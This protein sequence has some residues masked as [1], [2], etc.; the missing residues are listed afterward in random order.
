MLIKICGLCRR[1]DAAVAAGA[2]ATHV[3]VIRVS[4]AAR[5]RPTAVARSVLAGAR[6]CRRVG[7]FV[8][9]PADVVLEDAGALSLDV[10]QLHGREDAMAV[11]SLR[12]AGLEVWKVVKPATA[13]SLLELA[14]R[15][16]AA[17]LLLVEGASARGHGGVGARFDWDGVEAVLERLPAGVRLGIAGGLTPDNVA[18]AVRRFRPAL[19][20]VSSG[21]E[22]APGEKDPE[23]VRA[24]V[25]RAR[26]EAEAVDAMT[27]EG[28]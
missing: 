26:A 23:R 11:E 3:G 2:G 24:F 25:A 5:A 14:E 17:D 10:A 9:A 7:V 6:G 18:E 13:G 28:R 27:L 16:A 21:V 1:D 19:V 12:S 22:S 20:D 4:G 8:D 15:Y